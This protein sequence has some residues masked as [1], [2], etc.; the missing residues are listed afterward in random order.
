MF[1]LVYLVIFKN[2]I[3]NLNLIIEWTYEQS[4]NTEKMPAA[5]SGG[6]VI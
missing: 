5:A 2:N 1:P 3:L 4:A 6:R